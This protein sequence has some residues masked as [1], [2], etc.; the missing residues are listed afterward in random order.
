[1]LNH[2][3]RGHFSII[4]R[5]FIHP[6]RDHDPHKNCIQP[7]SSICSAKRETV[8]RCRISFTGFRIRCY[9]QNA[10]VILVR[11][12][13]HGNAA[14]AVNVNWIYPHCRN[15]RVVP[16]KDHSKDHYH[17]GVPSPIRTAMAL[18]IKQYSNIF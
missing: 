1:M 15:I 12:D 3:K 7:L 5:H 8:S 11:G 4:L 6:F 10:L 18:S 9:Y 16:I 13:C 2:T 17:K 14:G